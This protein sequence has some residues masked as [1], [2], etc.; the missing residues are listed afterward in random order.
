MSEDKDKAEFS[1]MSC[2]FRSV[3]VN[4]RSLCA[5]VIAVIEAASV[6]PIERIACLTSGDHVC[7]YLIGGG[8]RS[9]V[10]AS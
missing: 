9:K 6:S 1:L 3:A 2:K 5:Y 4:T 7:K 10:S 8:I